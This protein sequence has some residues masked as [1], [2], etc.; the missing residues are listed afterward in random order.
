MTLAIQPVSLLFLPLS[1]SICFPIAQNSDPCDQV[2]LE[3]VSPI[4][5]TDEHWEDEIDNFWEAWGRV[6]HLPRR[7]A[8][9]GSH[10]HV[11]P[12]P[13]KRF[14]LYELKAIASGVI[15]YDDNLD[16]I[17]PRPR[18]HNK[19]CQRNWEN[20]QSLAMWYTDGDKR[21]LAPTI[22]RI[23]DCD[24]ILELKNLMQD[25]RRVLWNFEHALPGSTG[26]V[27]F[28]GGR[29]L[30]GPNRTKWW[31]AFVIAFIQLCISQV[32]RAEPGRAAFDINT[33]QGLPVQDLG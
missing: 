21:T 31:I 17:L 12:G 30:R 11:S 1:S 4:L 5:R 6:F 18:Q 32:S 29:G 10:I 3:A 16:D 23:Y 8:K 25:N 7:S 26:T 33:V 14:T 27:E 22:L 2:P 13:N 24:T 28:R 15:F 9:C 20:S 19:Y